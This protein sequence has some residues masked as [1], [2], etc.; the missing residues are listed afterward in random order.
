MS[1]PPFDPAEVLDLA[2]IAAIAGIPYGT[3]KKRHARGKL[4]R[5]AGYVSG[6]PWWFRSAVLAH[7]K[8]HP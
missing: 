5:P 6:N 8:E 4:P 2:A 3:A 7:L 1:S